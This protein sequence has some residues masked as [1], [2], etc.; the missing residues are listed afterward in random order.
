MQEHDNTNDVSAKVADTRDVSKSQ[1]W[2]RRIALFCIVV[3]LVGMLVCTGLLM[4]AYITGH[5]AFELLGYGSYKPGFELLG[6]YAS[7]F[8]ISAYLALLIALNIPTLV[9]T[10][11]KRLGYIS[12]LIGIALLLLS[13]RLFFVSHKPEQEWWGYFSVVTINV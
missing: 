5:S 3:A 13:F 11:H 8:N 2:E 9:G 1:V 6:Y 10:E 4:Q 12:A 7:V